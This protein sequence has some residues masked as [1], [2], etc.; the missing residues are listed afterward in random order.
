MNNVVELEVV[1]E[2]PPHRDE[3]PP[4]GNPKGGPFVRAVRPFGLACRT[5]SGRI[6][7]GSSAIG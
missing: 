4:N 2:E 5:V 3:E 7:V 6:G 1:K